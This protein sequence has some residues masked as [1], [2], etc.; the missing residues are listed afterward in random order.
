MSI[1]LNVVSIA[2]VFCASLSRCAIRCLIR[3]IFIWT[4]KHNLLIKMMS[5]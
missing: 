4:Y 2:Q 1:S 3:F 5:C